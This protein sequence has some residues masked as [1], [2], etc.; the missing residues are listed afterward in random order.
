M[1]F[2]LLKCCLSVFNTSRKFLDLIL[3]NFLVQSLLLYGRVTWYILKFLILLI[4]SI[5]LN[6][7]YLHF[8]WVISS[9]LLILSLILFHVL[10]TQ[11]YSPESWTSVIIFFRSFSWFVVKLA[12]LFLIASWALARVWF[13]ILW[14]F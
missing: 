1:I 10:F 2:Y 3:E 11:D 13:F 8:I 5:P 12:C 6:F 4:F 7:S 14:I 9:G